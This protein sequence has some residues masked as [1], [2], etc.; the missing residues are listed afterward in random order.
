MSSAL[1]ANPL[2]SGQLLGEVSFS[3]TSYR[4]SRYIMGGGARYPYPKIVWSPAGGWWSRPSNW[5]TNTAMTAV[6]ITGIGAAVWKWSAAHEE[7]PVAPVK[8][9]P[10]R[11]WSQ[12]ARDAGIRME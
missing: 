7:R 4:P 3:A 11:Y 6:V 9:I 5:R 1:A 8:P 12:T 2:T 10:S